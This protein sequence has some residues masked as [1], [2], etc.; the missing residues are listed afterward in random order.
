[1]GRFPVR[2]SGLQALVTLS[3]IA[4]SAD[5]QLA[6]VAYEDMRNELEGAGYVFLMGRDGDVWDVRES[7]LLWKA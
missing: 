6:L 7:V 5:R 3:P 4:L 2:L 1:M